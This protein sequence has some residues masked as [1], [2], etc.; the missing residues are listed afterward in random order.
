VGFGQ[1]GPQRD[2]TAVGRDRL[3]NQQFLLKGA[4]E[5]VV[6]FGVAE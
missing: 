3:V 5:V 6:D 4:A 1:T 2:C